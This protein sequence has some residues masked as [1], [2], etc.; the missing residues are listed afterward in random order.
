MCACLRARWRRDFTCFD[1]RWGMRDDLT[2]PG[3]ACVWRVS[4]DSVVWVGRLVARASNCQRLLPLIDVP[5]TKSFV[6]APAIDRFLHRYQARWK[7]RVPSAPFCLGAFV[8]RGGPRCRR[9]VSRMQW[10]GG[11]IWSGS[12]SNVLSLS[13][14]RMNDARYPCCS[15][16]VQCRQAC[17]LQRRV[18]MLPCWSCQ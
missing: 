5:P 7:R 9:S 17:G 16:T 18:G 13:L 3:L 1:A 6:G 8:H 15:H 2:M 11:M 14:A 4:G 10:I 12:P